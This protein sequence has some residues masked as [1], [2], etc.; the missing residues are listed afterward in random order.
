MNNLKRVLSLALSGIMLVGMMAVGASAAEFSDADEI[1]NSEAVGSMVALNIIKGNDDGTFAPDR[2][3]TRAEMAKMISVALNGGKEFNFGTKVTPT[4]TDIK[5][6]WAESYIEYC[7]SLKIISGRGDGTF[8]PAGTVTGTEAAKMMLTALGFEAE[9]YKFVGADWA[10]N[11]NREASSAGLYDGLDI[12]PSEGMSRDN[13]AQLIWNGVQAKTLT[14]TPTQSI[15]TG[16]ITFTYNLNG[17]SILADK[18]GALVWIGTFTGN[19]DTGSGAGKGEVTINGKLDTDN[20]EKVPTDAHLPSDLDISNIGEEVKVIFKDGVNSKDSKPSKHDT[21]YGVY[22]TG[23]TVVY[24][25]TL[26]AIKDGDDAKGKIKFDD[27]SYDVAA[28]DGTSGKDAK[29]VITTNYGAEKTVEYTT[30]A[31]A[32]AAVEALKA[33]KNG[34]TV[35]FVTNVDGKICKAYV[36]KSD[37]AVVLSKNAEKITLNNGYGAIKIADNNVYEDVKKD[38]VVVATRIYNSDAEDGYTIVKKA[39]VVSGEVKGFKLQENVNLDGTT[40]KIYGEKDLFDSGLGSDAKKTFDKQIGETFDLYLVNGYVRAAVQTSEAASNWSVVLETKDG[41]QTGSVFNGLELQV[42]NADGT[43]SIIKVSK[44]TK[45]DVVPRED[46]KNLQAKDIPQGS[47]ITYTMNKDNEAVIKD[48]SKYETKTNMAYNKDTKTFGGATTTAECVLFVN[49]A[50]DGVIGDSKTSIT[51][52]AYKIRD[53]GAIESANA[54]VAK[55]SD[56]KVVAA[57]IDLKKSPVGAASSRVYGIVTADNGTVKVD[58]DQKNSYTVSSNGEE[59]TLYLTNDSL[60]KGDLVSFEPANDNIYAGVD[61][62]KAEDGTNNGHKI[63]DGV[64]NAV[65]GWVKEHNEKDGTLAI[66]NGLTALDKN[67]KP[68]TKPADVVSYKG[69]GES[70]YAVNKDTKFYFVDQDNYKGVEADSLSSFDVI[71]GYSNVIVI[72]SIENE[73]KDNETVFADVVIFETSGNA[74]ILKL[75]DGVRLEKPKK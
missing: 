3:V 66:W 41:G 50:K 44:D 2:V 9:I 35:K 7:A 20:A 42:M 11:T 55:D 58:G 46:G 28:G 24:N 71:K 48:F 47:L 51:M 18:Y 33:A 12:D 10:I 74:D 63:A 56:G 5:G 45:T 1:V 37:I 31:A 65:Q 57:V 19:H 73:G 14:K 17:P 60:K 23:K 6:H 8:D 22:N 32:A 70:T 26:G 53:L 34:D 59:Y 69:K 36:V 13:A 39:E 75:A 43:K 52:K 16:E 61:A 30:P 40:Y 68:T 49:T 21:I 4:Y 27:T 25:T 64:A 29:F 15:T 54:I 67:G 72:Y 38:D 62:T